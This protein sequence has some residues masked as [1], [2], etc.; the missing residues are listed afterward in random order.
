MPET[1]IISKMSV[2]TIKANPRVAS[3]EPEGSTKKFK[4]AQ[5][6]G[7]ANGTKIVED[8]NSGDSHESL[9]GNFEAKNLQ[10][11]TMYSSGVLYL[12]KGI[13]ESVVAAVKGLTNDNDSISFALE[14]SAVPANNPIGYSYEAVSLMKP[15]G[16]DPL[17]AIRAALPQHD[18]PAKE[19]PAPAAKGKK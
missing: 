13:H 19:L 11:G 6:Y 5:I 14:I 2:K 12:P 17:E 18:A 3:V 16:V 1:T 10:D 4:L 9:T 8:R 7:Q 15:V